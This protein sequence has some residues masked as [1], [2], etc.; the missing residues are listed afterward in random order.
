[1]SLLKL[2]S[3]FLSLQV[4]DDSDDSRLW[5]FQVNFIDS[6]VNFVDTLLNYFIDYKILG[7]SLLKSRRFAYYSN[8]KLLTLTTG[9]LV[10]LGTDFFCRNSTECIGGETCFA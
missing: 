1:M 6:Q 2:L 8:L 5:D 10:S 4:G 3:F 7:L 9:I